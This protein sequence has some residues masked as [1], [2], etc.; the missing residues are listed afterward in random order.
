MEKER[1]G[2]NQQQYTFGVVFLE[3]KTTQKRKKSTN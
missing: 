3:K 1:I 2:K